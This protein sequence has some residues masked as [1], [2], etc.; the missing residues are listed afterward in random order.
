MFVAR[1]SCFFTATWREPRRQTIREPSERQHRQPLGRS[2][3]SRRL[4]IRSTIVGCLG[5]PR[6]NQPGDDDDRS[7]NCRAQ[8]RQVSRVRHRSFERWLRY[9]EYAEPVPRSI[10]GRD[11]YLCRQS[12]SRL[13]SR[14]GWLATQFAGC[15]I[16]ATI[17]ARQRPRPREWSTASLRRRTRVCQRIRPWAV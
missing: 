1:S 5:Q 3:A 2:Q 17:E 10:C 15:F 11:S 16:R 12:R 4:S 7:S 14:T 9:L 13:C 8:G 6:D